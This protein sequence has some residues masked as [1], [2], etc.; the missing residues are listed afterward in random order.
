MASLVSLLL[1]PKNLLILALSVALAGTW[2]AYDLKKHAA[3][4]CS[5]ELA[6][7][8]A[9][10]DGYQAEISSANSIIETLKANLAAIRRQAAEWQKI[11]SEAHDLRLRI[12]A[13][14]S[15]PK[16]CEVLHAEYQKVAGDIT[17]YFNAGSVRGKVNRPDPAGDR[18]APE[19]LPGPGAA[20]AGGA[21]DDA[22]PAR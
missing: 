21:E 14:Q 18:A 7:C 16:E 17:L 11:A 12:F 4:T 19:V 22:R 8:E 1:N 2:F 10:V 3:M 13:L 5:G 15:S 6:L 20:G 9:N